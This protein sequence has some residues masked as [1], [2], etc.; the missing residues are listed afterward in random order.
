MPNA[1]LDDECSAKGA[2][3]AAWYATVIFAFLYWLS[4]LDRFVITLL[5]EPIKRDLGISDIQFA[6]LHGAAFTLSFAVIGLLAGAL[7]D[8]FNRRWVIFGCV[9]IWSLATAACG[10]VQNFW[11]LII[12]RLGVGAGE[13]GLNPCATSI[14]ADLFPRE[15]LTLAMAVFAMGSTL[16]SGCAYLLGGKIVDWASRLDTLWR[17][18]SL[19]RSTP[20]KPFFILLVFLGYYFRC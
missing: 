16:G 3:F 7:A 4:I 2:G 5:V 6:I 9:T 17:F 19:A 14:I 11:Q 18:R 8:R 15:R 1:K 13:T 12:A 20:G 10:M